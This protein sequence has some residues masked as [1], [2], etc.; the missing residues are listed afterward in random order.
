MRKLNKIF[1]VLKVQKRIV[2][3]KTIRGNTV[4]SNWGLFNIVKFLLFFLIQPL[5][6]ARA[7]FCKKFR[8]FFG[9]S[10]EKKKNLL[11]ITDL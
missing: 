3:G 2:Y 1:K 4:I 11:R 7:E 8:G 5:L 9:V 10:E 6:E